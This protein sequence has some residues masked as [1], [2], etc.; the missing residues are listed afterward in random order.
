[1]QHNSWYRRAGMAGFIGVLAIWLAG[2]GAVVTS[3]PPLQATTSISVVKPYPTPTSAQAL[4]SNALTAPAAG[5]ANGPECAFTANGLVVRPNNGQA[6]ICLAPTAPLADVSVTV[7]VQQMNSPSTH[8]FGIAFRHAAPKNYYFFG[9]DGKGSFTFTT[10][11]N[12]VSHTIIPFTPKAVIHSGANAINRLQVI[13][14]GQVITL[15]VNGT[16]VGQATLAT[17]ASG[18]VGLRG[19]NNGEVIFQQLSI[20]Q[21]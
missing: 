7:T 19:I 17:F 21:V 2:C 4:Y 3:P 8:A 13:A 1:M 15:L 14:R 18:S 16:P 10:V 11:I 12:D 20:A 5:W 9:I 6:Y